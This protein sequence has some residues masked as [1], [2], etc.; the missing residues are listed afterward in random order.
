MTQDYV[1]VKI[2]RKFA[3]HSSQ[4]IF[5]LYSLKTITDF[6]NVLLSGKEKLPQNI[7]IASES[8]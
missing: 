2:I 3:K 5:N 1:M 4:I 7:L 6:N 8:G